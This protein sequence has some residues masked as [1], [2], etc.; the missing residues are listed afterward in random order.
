MS[1]PALVVAALLGAALPGSLLDLT[2]YDPSSVW[3][4]GNMVSDLDDLARLYPRCSP[5]RLLSPAALEETKGRGRP[6]PAAAR[7][8]FELTGSG[9]AARPWPARD[10]AGPAPHRGR[11][12]QR[13]RRRI[14]RAGESRRCGSDSRGRWHGTRG[15]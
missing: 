6:W 13:D 8:Q 1:V 9:R 11:R 15:R 7:E 14:C 3:A 10:G 5:E 12:V 4:A 2:T